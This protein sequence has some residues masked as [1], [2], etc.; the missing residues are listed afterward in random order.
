LCHSAS[1][2]RFRPATRRNRVHDFAFACPDGIERYI[3]VE[4]CLAELKAAPL[5]GFGAMIDI[6]LAGGALSWF[7]LAL[8]KEVLLPETIP[9][10]GIS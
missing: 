8:K 4:L 7:G 3:A 2:G 10:R 6:M 1:P 5:A 9:Q